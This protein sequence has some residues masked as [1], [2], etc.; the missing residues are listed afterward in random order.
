MPNNKS[1][2]I[3]NLN[4]GRLLQECTR[5]YLQNLG[6]R[7][8][9]P[10]VLCLQD[11]PF[12]DL[13]FLERW[14]HVTFAP[15]T[16][17]LINGIRAVVGIAIASRYFMT[18]IVHRTVW[19][20]GAL[21]DLKGINDRNQRYLGAE[22]DRLVE[23]TE[24]RVA[25]CVTVVKDGVEY[26][27]ATTH[28]MWVRDGI[29]NDVQRQCASNTIDFLANEATVRGGLVLTADMNFGRDGEIYKMFTDEFRDCMP[30]EIDSTL[31][32]EHPAMKK[33]IKVVADYVM[34]AD[35]FSEIYDIADVRLQSGVS[36]HCALSATIEKEY[37][38]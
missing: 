27:I 14:P 11:I 17:H 23:A 7:I 10:D 35:T 33:G 25:I 6:T 32:P 8:D 2:S 31:D 1:L 26:D 9:P 37:R 18:N 20:N 12:H 5:V 34:V 13:P 28:G 3:V 15:M 29:T 36:D 38:L 19:G 30:P 21:K 22:S 16:N 24:D 4:A